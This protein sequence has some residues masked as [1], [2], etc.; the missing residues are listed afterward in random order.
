MATKRQIIAREAAKRAAQAAYQ[1]IMD[2]PVRKIATV[3]GPQEVASDPKEIARIA[4]ECAYKSIISLAQGQTQITPGTGEGG[5]DA[6]TPPQTF[7][8]NKPSI[9][10][11]VALKEKYPNCARAYDLYRT[12]EQIPNDV[13]QNATTEWRGGGK[14]W[15]QQNEPLVYNGL[16]TFLK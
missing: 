1:A 13:L 8:P 6:G 7:S 4:A 15:I 11:G 14:Q 2:A 12:G 3:L 16:S 10:Q 9:G 5:V